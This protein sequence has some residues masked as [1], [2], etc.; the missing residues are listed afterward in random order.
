MLIC[1]TVA[2]IVNS[3]LKAT[4]PHIIIDVDFIFYRLEY[5]SWHLS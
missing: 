4:V 1:G 5:N 2:I 3:L